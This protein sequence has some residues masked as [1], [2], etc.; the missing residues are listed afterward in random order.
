MLCGDGVHF[1][2]FKD[3]NWSDESHIARPDEINDLPENFHLLDFPL[4][5][6]NGFAFI[7]NPA[8]MSSGKRINYTYPLYIL[9]Q[10][11]IDDPQKCDLSQPRLVITKD[12]F[13][14][15]AVALSENDQLL[16]VAFAA[17]SK[18]EIC[19]YDLQTQKVVNRIPLP[20][21]EQDSNWSDVGSMIWGSQPNQIIL[22]MNY[23]PQIYTIPD[24]RKNDIE[25]LFNCSAA[26]VDNCS[27]LSKV[28]VR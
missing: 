7:I 19:I 8:N 22:S 9:G 10:E 23:T 2:E 15:L 4:W 17:H 11:C 27:I 3:G 1:F 20:T 21:N 14:V 13:S 18:G 26:N 28:T 6:K 5:M 25:M 16:A 24:Y 12:S